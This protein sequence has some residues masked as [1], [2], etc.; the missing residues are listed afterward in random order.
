MIVLTLEDS[1]RDRALPIESE[2][3]QA[4]LREM[5]YAVDFALANRSLMMDRIVGAFGDSIDD[6]IIFDKPINI[7]HNYA[8]LENHFRENVWVH[9]K[10]ATL[11]REGTIGIIP[12][13][14]GTKS[15]IVEGLG[16]KDSFESCSHGAGRK[17]GRKEAIRTL[18]LEEEQKKMEG[19][20]GSPRTQED[21]EEAPG[22]YKNI[23]EVMENQKDLVKIKVELKPL[24]V[25]KG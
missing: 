6:L 3:G 7:A 2:E 20:L 16:N 13:S 4:Y 1:T 19:I 22:S 21:L 14:M 23:D 12:G 9:R 10:G 18:N 24:A 11:A 17:M 5:N 15:Y 25:I 8:S